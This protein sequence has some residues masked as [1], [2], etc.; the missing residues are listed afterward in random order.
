MT[1][2]NKSD[3]VNYRSFRVIKDF[4]DNVLGGAKEG[5][6]DKKHPAI[7]E[8]YVALGRYVD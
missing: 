4:L 2:A 3:P 7:R 1:P 5:G 6:G 8:M